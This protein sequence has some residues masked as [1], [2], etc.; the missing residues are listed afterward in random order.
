MRFNVIRW[1]N[2][3]THRLTKP[4]HPGTNCQVERVTLMIKDSTVKRFHDDSHNQLRTHLNDFMVAYD[5]ARRLKTLGGPT[6]Y[7]C[8]YKEWTSTQDRF[9][10]NLIH[11][12]PRLS[13]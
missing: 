3:I 8:I 9:I 4:N 11:Q 5:F 7:T 10:P 13:T 1:D 12:M 2:G 6:P